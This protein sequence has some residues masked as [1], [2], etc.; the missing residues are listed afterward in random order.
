MK[1]K[2]YTILTGITPSGDGEVHLGNYFGAVVP[3]LKMAQKAKR[4]YLLS[5]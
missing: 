5:L 4:V 2:S 1:N 3:F